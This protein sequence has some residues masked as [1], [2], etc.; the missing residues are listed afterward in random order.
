MR[1]RR[2]LLSLFLVAF[3]VG[4]G[5][6]E[7]AKP[8]SSSSA[9]KPAGK[10]R[11][12]IGVS[13]LTLTN[14]FFKVI[15]DSI[16]T[17]AASQ[18]YDVIAVSGDFDVAKQQNQV[19]DFIVKKV[20]A[21]VLC[22][23]DSKA[24]GPVIQEANTAGIPV[25]TCDIK[26]LAPGASVISHIATDN[27]QGG[28]L[29][30]DAMIEALGE[31][32]GKIVVLDFKQAESCIL[33]VKGFK[34]VLEAHNTKAVGKNKIEIVAELPGDGQ[35][36]KAFKAAEDALQAHGDLAGV[37]AINDPSALGARAAIEKA[38]KAGQ[39]KIIGFDGQPEGKQA[40]R[41]GK[42]YA[43]PVQ[44]PER[45]GSQ[46]MQAILKYFEGEKVPTDIL[47]PTALYRKAD[48]EKD[49]T[50]K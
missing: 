44:F 3:C 48:A 5:Q 6:T 43:D 37:F 26:C 19:K 47:I 29:A 10:K 28:K 30:G 21:I 36:D 23:C 18:G 33:R 46:T 38:G 20:S 8:N 12:T 16:T 13:V 49:S 45:I 50:L 32:G 24:I 7:P 14:P 34:E 4:C 39:V 25:F 17:E 41:D 1:F 2:L 22:P 42:I 15:A 9:E 11:G 40:I 27:Y 35:K 31:G